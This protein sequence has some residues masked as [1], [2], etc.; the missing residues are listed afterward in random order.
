MKVGSR[1]Q[2]CMSASPEMD[3]CISLADQSG[4]SVEKVYRAALVEWERGDKK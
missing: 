4:I 1:N 2:I 3:D